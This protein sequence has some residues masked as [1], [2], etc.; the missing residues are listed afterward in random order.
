MILL[1]ELID[2]LQ[3][4]CPDVLVETVGGY[5]A[6]SYPPSNLN[7]IHPK[8]RVV[9]AHW[10]RHHI[11]G[12]DDPGYDKRNL[13]NWRKAAKGGLTICQYYTVIFAEPWVMGPF[14]IAMESD[15]RYFLKHH[16]DA[17]YMLMY[18]RGY[19]WNHS[20]NGY[21][22]GRCFYDV[23]IDPFAEINDYA[24][25]YFGPDAG[26]LLAAY[27]M[28]WAKEIDLSYRV[29]SNSRKQDRA[30]LAEQ[31]AKWINPAVDAAKQNPLY[32]YRVSKVDKLHTLAEHLTE[33]HRLHDVV[34]L[35]RQQGKFDDAA[36]LLDKARAYT[37]EVMTL[38]YTLADLN[39]GLIE[40]KEVPGFIRKGVKDWID[41]EAKAIAG[42]SKTVAPNPWKQ[43]SET[44]MLPADVAR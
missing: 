14:A 22:G 18:P 28:Q 27:Y 37:D 36:R 32:A 12:Y 11:R 34:Q 33:G 24:L 17:M 19:W 5:G 7:I 38:F 35:L 40:R 16:V 1:G 43:L 6:V 3:T 8:Q 31:R 15:R 30:M 23:T 29:R 26:P 9:W 20:L 10:G 39:Q 21:I 13:D 44:D 4:S 42:K 25:H 2:K 41:D